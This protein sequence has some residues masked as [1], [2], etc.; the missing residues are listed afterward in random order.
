VHKH[1]MAS[2]VGDEA[3]RHDPE[4]AIGPVYAGTPTGAQRDGELLPQEQ[5]LHHE[6]LPAPKGNESSAD[7]ERQPVQHGA[8][9]AY[10]VSHHADGVLAPHRT[11]TGDILREMTSLAAE[12]RAGSQPIK[13]ARRRG[14]KAKWTR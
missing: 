9:I 8:M 3:S 5:V 11:D 13:L 12:A 2:L 6:G 1:E 7:E 10:G 4:E 14:A